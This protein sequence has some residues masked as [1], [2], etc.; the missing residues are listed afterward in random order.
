MERM[1]L[2]ELA[3]K[4]VEQR[5]KWSPTRA[6]IE[7]D[8][9]YQALQTEID[10]YAVQRGIPVSHLNFFWKPVQGSNV[11]KRNSRVKALEGLL[12]S[13]QLWFCLPNPQTTELLLAQFVRFD[14]IRKS[15]SADTSKDDGPDVVSSIWEAY[16]PKEFGDLIPDVQQEIDEQQRMAAHLKGL[17]DRYFGALEPPR[18]GPVYTAPEQPTGGI[19]G[20]LGRFGMVRAA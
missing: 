1:R 17:H 8:G 19:H 12:A 4:I 14:G 13:D 16:G 3:Q 6:L 15:G 18:P 7:K 10:K 9:Y 20:T 2:T 5:Q 11:K